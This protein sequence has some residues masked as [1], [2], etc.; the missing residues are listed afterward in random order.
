[1]CFTTQQSLKAQALENRYKARLND[2]T[3]MPGI[4]RG[5]AFP[6]TP[7][8]CNTNPE[9]IEMVQW[10]LIPYWAK[11]PSIQRYTLNA[12][13]ETLHEKPSFKHCIAQPCIVLVDAF[14]EWQWMD[15]KGSKKQAYRLYL[16]EEPGFSIAGLWSIWINP[17]TGQEQKT[18]TIITQEAQGVM[19]EIHNR[20]KRMPYI[21]NQ[22]QE[23]LWLEQKHVDNAFEQIQ[24]EP[25][26]LRGAG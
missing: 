20:T 16:N 4:F 8:I 19:R 6:K 15:S 23:R 2:T 26:N 9:N 21:L 18:Y 25:V 13:F 22:S 3:Y 10:G 5:F 11:D 12:R 14:Y 1:M 17:L 7:V 24:A